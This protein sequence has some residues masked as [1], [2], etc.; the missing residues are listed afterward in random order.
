MVGRWQ[1]KKAE[2]HGKIKSAKNKV[3]KGILIETL[4]IINVN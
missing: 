1:C 2:K 4:L 3:I